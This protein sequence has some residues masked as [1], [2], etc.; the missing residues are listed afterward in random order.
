MKYTIINVMVVISLLLLM[1]GFKPVESEYNK[2]FKVGY[3]EGW[4]DVKGKWAICPYP[5]YPAYPTYPRV[6]TSFRDGFIVG[7]KKGTKAAN[8]N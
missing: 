1:T 3:C 6:S 7:F 8:N 2:G 4:K 5:P